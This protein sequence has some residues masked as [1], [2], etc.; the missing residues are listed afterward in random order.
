MEELNNLE[1]NKKIKE[2]IEKEKQIFDIINS[3][4][5]PINNLTHKTDN[6]KLINPIFSKGITEPENT[7]KICDKFENF[8]KN[9]LNY[10]EKIQ[11][12]FLESKKKDDTIKK[13]LEYIGTKFNL[14]YKNIKITNKKINFEKF[15]IKSITSPYLAITNEKEILFS[16]NSFE[17]NIGPYVP[18]LYLNNKIITFNIISF[19]DKNIE[20]KLI[21]NDDSPFKNYFD[22]SK[23]IPPTNPIKISYRHLGN[24]KY[25]EPKEVITTGTIIIKIQN[26]DIIKEIPFKFISQ[27]MP[28]QIFLECSK[29]LYY[30]NNTFIF[31]NK[32][33]Y[34]DE[35]IIF[36]LNIPNTEFNCKYFFQN[37]YL[38]Y[39]ENN[40]VEIPK[41]IYDKINDEI[42][43]IIPSIK[44]N[45]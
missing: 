6:I 30:E 14:Q 15:K 22:I 38:T 32:Y 18:P 28:L 44:E 39:I 37:I 19:I 11:K 23:V 29:N 36:I 24:E 41:I 9:I 21:I 34:A 43:L 16:L 40:E 7:K 33:F 35:S 45:K 17:K 5:T 12:F 3:F 2:F 4:N 8:K 25:N 1:I 26:E 31:K 27:I 20:A 42:Q 10:F 13:C